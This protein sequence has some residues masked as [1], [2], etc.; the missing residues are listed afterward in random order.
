MGLWFLVNA[1]VWMFYEYA[2]WW[3]WRLIC[4]VG[5]MIW[6]LIMCVVA[7]SAGLFDRFV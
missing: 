6:C 3:V 5:F 1:K 7:G 4:G 2:C